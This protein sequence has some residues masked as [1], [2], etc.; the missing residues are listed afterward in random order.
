MQYVLPKNVRINSV[1]FLRALLIFMQISIAYDR[2]AN[3]STGFDSSGPLNG[4]SH[5]INKLMHI[6]LWVEH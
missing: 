1:V 5:I 4:A 2:V 3:H 6:A